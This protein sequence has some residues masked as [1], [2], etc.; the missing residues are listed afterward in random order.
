MESTESVSIR[1]ARSTDIDPLVELLEQLFLL[2]PDFPIDKDRQRRGLGLM[3]DSPETRTILVADVAGRVVGMCS[4]QIVVSTAEGGPV[5]W[6]EDVVVE[7]SSQGRGIGRKLL[8]EIEAW[9]VERGGTR[10]QLIADRENHPSLEFYQRLGWEP[11][12]LVCY[13]RKNRDAEP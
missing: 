2:E 7:T 11:T 3:L 10:L 8:A 4:A 5:A 12:R 9:V 6:I 13:R 1:S